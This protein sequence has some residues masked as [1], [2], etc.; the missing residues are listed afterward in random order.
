MHACMHVMCR[1]E[2]E[3]T[4]KSVHLCEFVFHQ[5]CAL[6]TYRFSQLLPRPDVS[7][8]QTTRFQG[9]C[10][11]PAVLGGRLAVFVV[12]EVDGNVGGRG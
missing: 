12:V 9:V 5:D 7:E 6:H 2:G 3:L 4:R 8:H 11:E 1:M 10:F